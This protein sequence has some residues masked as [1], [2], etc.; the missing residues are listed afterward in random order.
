MTPRKFGSGIA[1]HVVVILVGTVLVGLGT[2]SHGYVFD[3][4]LL[5]A[6]N[7]ELMSGEAPLWKAFS[8]RYWGAADEAAANELYRP[9]T[10]ASLALNVRLLGNDAAGLH[11]V[12]VALH[13]L[14]ALLAYAL[15]RM[16]F[17]R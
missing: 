8:S 14:N 2:L 12:N 7:G 10:V 9:T 5:L 16:L 13:A 1:L 15:I 4:H 6:G 17:G 3:D 11:A